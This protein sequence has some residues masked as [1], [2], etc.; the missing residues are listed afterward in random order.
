MA[1]GYASATHARAGAELVIP[2][3]G[4]AAI[5]Y[6][7]PVTAEVYTVPTSARPGGFVLDAGHDSCRIRLAHDAAS[8]LRKSRD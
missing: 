1:F 5:R 3:G 2:S 8:E 7:Q 4:V 6:P